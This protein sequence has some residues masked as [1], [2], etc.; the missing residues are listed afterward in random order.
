MR[1]VHF[2][3]MTGAGN[4]FLVLENIRRMNPQK[5]AVSMC[6]R[7]TGVG[8][9]GLLLLERSSKA[10]YRMRIINSDGSEAEMCG[11]G[12]RCMAAYI[13]RHKSPKHKIFSLE[14]LAGI[15]LGQAHGEKAVVRLIDP[16]DFEPNIPLKVNGRTIHV[17]YIDTGVPHTIVFVDGLKGIDVNSIGRSI[18]HHERFKPRGTNVDFVE[19]LDKDAV[20]VRTFERGVE[21]ETLAC[22]TGSVAC[23]IVGFLKAHPKIDSTHKASMS[24]LTKSGET[25]DLSFKLEKRKIS[26]VWLKGSAK[27]IAEG[28]YYV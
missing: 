7:N 4:D 28:D 25:L 19:Q 17:S 20:A 12:S 8:A 24:I 10:D 21:G 13:V 1:T 3:K 14:T 5:L 9:D 6:A 15:V 26:D 2:T 18:R 16:K 23:G 11:N 27:F 22:G